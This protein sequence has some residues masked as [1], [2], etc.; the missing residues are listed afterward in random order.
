MDATT[1][2]RRSV[3]SALT[4][5]TGYQLQRAET[6][7]H[8]ATALKAA[9]AAAY[10]ARTAQSKAEDRA[11]RARRRAKQAER[12][13]KQ[14]RREA[15][16]R[17]RYALHPDFDDAAKDIIMTVKPRT[18]TS[19]D[20]LFGLISAARYVVEHDIPGDVVE[21]G[22]WRGGS[23]QATAMAFLQA[24]STARHLY[25]FD[26]FEG[27][28]PPS[29]ADLRRDGTPAAELLASA[30]KAAHVWAIAGLDD[31]R[32]GM[33]EVGY[34]ADKVHFIKGMVEDTVPAEAPETISILRLDTD[35]Y[36][37]TRHELEHLYPRL[38]SGGVLIIDD[39][40]YWQGSRK[41]TD[42]FL[43]DTGA[44]LLLNRISGGRMAV[45][46]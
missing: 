5:L 35:W 4:R 22:V 34:P 41:A 1:S 16:K 2:W 26:T 6:T 19:S 40:G 36:T 44:R 11:T 39:Y 3:N 23:M 25:L 42:E 18:M 37:S 7:R 24:D 32:D 17:N 9:T 43:A 20:K 30:G 13:V 33:E 45:K 15:M 8:M 27:M 14:V 29:D 46:P 31:V 10:T 38:V 12:E 28:P 21:C